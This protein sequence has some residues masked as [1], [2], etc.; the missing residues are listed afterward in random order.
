[1]DA[2]Q[3][4]G[5]KSFIGLL[6]DVA[7][8]TL[9]YGATISDYFF[10][11][12]YEK[13]HFARKKFMTARDKNRFYS[14]MN[15]TTNRGEIQNK[16]AFNE[17][18]SGY[19]KRD[20]V[21]LPDCGEQRFCE[22]LHDHEQVFIKP[23]AT[24]GGAG[25]VK[26]SEK[27]I[28]NISAYYKDLCGKGTFVVEAAIVQHS[29]MA[30]LHPQSVNTVRVSTLYDGEKVTILF[31]VLRCGTGDS[32]MDNHMKGGIVMLVDPQTG[33][34]SSRGSCKW[35][36]NIERHPDTNVLFPG[37]QIPHWDQC[38]A[39]IN[40]VATKTKGLR[41]IGW[42]IAI[43]QDGV[44][45][46]EANPSGDFNIYQE[47]MQRGCKKEMDEWITYIKNKETK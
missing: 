25:I 20:S 32:Y 18:F 28:E 40:Q 39:L 36:V 45:L 1:M 4:R 23:I 26:I 24:G 8:C 42:D 46:V 33:R 41:Y 10:F 16:D 3:L 27:E 11:R 6:L 29:E 37:F 47:P 19:L 21:A 7:F 2:Q 5:K 38:I 14:A 17:N 44:C 22:F 43:L 35:G 30:A 34:V 13:K 31:A 9:I 15:D 12:F